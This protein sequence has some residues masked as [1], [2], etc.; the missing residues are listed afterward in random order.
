MRILMMVIALVSIDFFSAAAQQTAGP[1]TVIS[2]RRGNAFSSPTRKIQARDETADVVLALRVSGLSRE[3][4]LKVDQ[5]AIYVMAGDEK[6]PPN[7]V[8]TGVVDGKAE[9]LVVCVGPRGTL[10]MTLV[11]GTYPRVA[12]KAE[13]EVAEEL[14]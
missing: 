1:L 13:E 4:F 2:A 7:I 8:A 3:E 11:L 9:L 6:L 5:S 12:F 14:R 10:E